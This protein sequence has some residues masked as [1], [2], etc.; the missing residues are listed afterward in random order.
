MYRVYISYR[1]LDSGDLA[2]RIYQYLE[3][4]LG[5]SV[6][7]KD[8][9]IPPGAE[10]HS[11]LRETLDTADVLIVVIG[12]DWLSVP[13]N[14][15]PRLF[16]PGDFHRS[17]IETALNSGKL[18]VPVIVNNA[19]M[20]TPAD[21]PDSIRDLYQR[22]SIRVRNEPN[23]KADLTKLADYLR[24]TLE[25]DPV[26]EDEA[27]TKNDKADGKE[28]GKD[29]P[30]LQI[31]LAIIALVG[32]LGA[33]LFGVL[34]DLID[35]LQVPTPTPTTMS[36]P[37]DV[38]T[39][40]PATAAVI[41]DAD[42]TATENALLVATNTANAV[43]TQT[44][45]ALILSTPPTEAATPTLTATPTTLPPITVPAPSDTPAPSSGDAVT[46]TIYRDEDSFT[47]HVPE[48]STQ[49]S[50]VGLEYRVQLFNGSTALRR[51]DWDFAAFRG[52]PFDNIS[53]L[54]QATCFRLVR[55]GANVPAPQD[56]QTALLL[57]QNIADADVFWYDLS[58]NITY[59]VQIVHNNNL[60]ALCAPGQVQCVVAWPND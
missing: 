53:S 40:I 42:L 26:K 27:P 15:Q 1:R 46:L 19:L 32:T 57:T 20:P 41:A 23:F 35:R 51:L 18:V 17:E 13:G 31:I 50:L 3:K 11:F 9:K 56:C 45:A 21:L 4:E 16:E 52:M 33:A 14:N 44:A 22:M 47:L 54:N 6:V 59:M 55:S 10:W 38:V 36:P 39:D 30:S 25:I 49:V 24:Q 8:D 7:F 48:S 28:E 60:I 29:K 58:T 12:P 5:E 43:E 34:P 37:T 2:R